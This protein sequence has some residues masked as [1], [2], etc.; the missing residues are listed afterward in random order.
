M[1]RQYLTEVPDIPPDHHPPLAGVPKTPPQVGPSALRRQEEK[2]MKRFLAR[3]VR[4]CSFPYIKLGDFL[5][6]FVRKRQVSVATKYIVLFAVYHM[7]RLK[8]FV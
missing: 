7:L 1:L 8:I 6:S 5:L 4:C 3:T 2:E